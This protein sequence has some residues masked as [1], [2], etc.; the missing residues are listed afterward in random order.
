MSI[1][2]RGCLLALVSAYWM[3]SH[4]GGEGGDIGVR[5]KVEEEKVWMKSG[6]TEGTTSRIWGFER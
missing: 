4:S 6:T 3:V 2:G 1:R 5:C